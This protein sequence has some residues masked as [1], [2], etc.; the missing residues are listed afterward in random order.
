M[1]HLPEGRQTMSLKRAL[2]LLLIVLY[3]VHSPDETLAGWRPH[4]A[5]S[6]VPVSQVA[7]AT[8]TPT[9][10]NVAT[11]ITAALNVRR[12]P[13]PGY[14]VITAVPGGTKLIVLEE[15][16]TARWLRVR[17]PDGREGWVSRAFTDFPGL[18]PVPA[19]PTSA[20]TP[21]PTPNMAPTPT[22]TYTPTPTPI[23]TVTPTPTATYAPMA[24]PTA[25]HAQPSPTP[26]SVPPTAISTAVASPGT[27]E[28]RIPA[29][30]PIAK[31]V[32]WTLPTL[33]GSDTLRLEGYRPSATFSL[34]LP[35]GWKLTADGQ[36]TL[37]YGISGL[38]LAGATL[39]VR[40]NDQ[41]FASVAFESDVGSL[42]LDLP[43]RLFQPGQN[44]VEL[45][46]FLP[47]EEDRDC[48]VPNHPARWLEFGPA[49]RIS[50]AVEPLE[51]PLSLANFPAQFEALG[52]DSGA[53]VTFVIPDEPDDYELSALSAVAF[54]LACGS[55]T[56]PGWVI[57]SASDF[58]S[59]QLTGPVIF[60]GTT[61]RNRYL[62]PLA[63]PDSRGF[64]WIS[65][66]RQDWS[67]GWPVLA[68]GGPD[69]QAVLP[70]ADA[71]ADPLATL[72]M[73]GQM[74]I[75]EMLP[76]Y[77]PAPPVEQFTLAELGYSERIA[78]G[79][80]EQSLIYVFDIPLA[81]SPGDSRLQL[82]FAHSAI[83]DPQVASLTVLMNARILSGIRLD[84]PESASN[85]VEIS[86]PK[87]LIRPGR[88]FL[89]L[90]FD[91]GTPIELCDF[92][93]AQ[94][95]WASVRPDT[96]LTLPHGESGG[97]LNLDDFPYLFAS[98]VDLAALT[99]VLPVQSTA[100]DFADALTLVRN[101]SVLGNLSPVAPRWVRADALK[102]VAR[103]ETFTQQ[104]SHLIV[105]GDL[106]QQPLLAELN[107]HLPLSFDLATGALLPSYGIRMPTDAPDL[108]V[109]QAL[110]SPWAENRV[111]LVIAG[112]SSVGYSRA[113]QLLTDPLL[114]PYLEGQLAVI[115]AGSDTDR[116]QVYTKVVA[117]VSAVPG[118][119]AID[120]FFS[121]FFGLG[122]P[123]PTIILVPTGL[124]ILAVASV[125]GLRWYRRRQA[126]QLEGH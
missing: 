57:V 44:I 110:R 66:T 25:T 73:S 47:L 88:N 26:T 103:S 41:S 94:G 52:D 58:N 32:I 60:I 31:T 7:T 96:V 82:H 42:K 54:A 106:S 78:R 97:R 40:L 67:G 75:I 13:S 34:T 6:S 105:L 86:I 68:V 22:A 70:A 100:T 120:R 71:L 95:P 119:S 43:A 115:A 16:S 20:P 9:E 8:P 56:H 74:A 84:A 35:P 23:P 19:E 4:T 121:R 81:W 87:A 46:A 5:Q 117:D 85:L 118:V 101:L 2:I 91:F 61:G 99:I 114:L 77:E 27:A 90:T 51:I 125:L 80:G 109:V 72:Q 50:M 112:T 36:L 3:A 53:Q 39:T 10:A 55:V 69:S 33:A 21:M 59:G 79:I 62:A 48:I 65:L 28:S 113:V 11:V 29:S 102:E 38:A 98:D 45:A 14:A 12:G 107:P 83:L 1:N 123:W 63:P 64:G 93:S 15:D 108:G 116:P 76:P 126:S 49:S 89:R 18:V 111:I 37:D 104:G 24:M 30:S 92:G 124:L 122:S 17:L